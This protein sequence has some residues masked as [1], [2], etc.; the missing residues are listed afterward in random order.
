MLGEIKMKITT[1]QMHSLPSFFNLGVAVG[2]VLCG[3]EGYE[4]ISDCE[5]TAGTQCIPYNA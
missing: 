5:L 1:Q 2:A 4:A 3:M